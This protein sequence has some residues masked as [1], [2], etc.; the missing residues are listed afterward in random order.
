ML[1]MN[2][3]RALLLIC[4]FIFAATQ[5]LTAQSSG[6]LLTNASDILSLSAVQASHRINVSIKGVVTAA[7]PD[8]NGKFFVQDATA[9]VFVNNTASSDGHWPVPG[10]VVEVSGV[11]SAGGYAPDISHPQW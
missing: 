5:T 6:E 1:P 9:G 11:S 2:K 4:G 10:D 8:W 3:S 7:E